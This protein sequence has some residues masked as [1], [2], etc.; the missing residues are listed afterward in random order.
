MG[1]AAWFVGEAFNISGVTVL[2]I[3]GLSIYLYL[4]LK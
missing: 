3:F 2:L 4:Y 1:F